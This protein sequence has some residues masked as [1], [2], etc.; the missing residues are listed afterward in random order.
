MTYPRSSSLSGFLTGQYQCRLSTCERRAPRTSQRAARG[1][2]RSWQLIS[3]AHKHGKESS[4]GFLPGIQP[5]LRAKQR[6]LGL[7]IEDGPGSP[8]L[9]DETIEVITWSTEYSLDDSWSSFQRLRLFRIRHSVPGTLHLYEPAN[10]AE[11]RQL[12]VASRFVVLDP[13]RS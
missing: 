3:R 8:G 11:E 6:Q 5:L 12:L 4:G 13:S 2:S 7:R 1:T 10:R 9:S